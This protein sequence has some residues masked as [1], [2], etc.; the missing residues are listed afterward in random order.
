MRKRGGRTL[1]LKSFFP[2]IYMGR[3]VEKKE[4]VQ[5][6]RQGKKGGVYSRLEKGARKVKYKKNEIPAS[7]K[8]SGWE[9]GVLKK[10]ADWEGTRVLAESS[11][12]EWSNWRERGTAIPKELGGGSCRQQLKRLDCE[13]SPQERREGPPRAPRKAERCF[14]DDGKGGERESC[15][16]M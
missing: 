6:G 1:L 13:K 9:N 16:G 4:R 8:T 7:K 3:P 15:R 12:V 14:R 11:P 10:E 2:N 5:D